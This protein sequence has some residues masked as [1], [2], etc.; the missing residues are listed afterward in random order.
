MAILLNQLFALIRLLNSETG[1][2]QIAAGISCGFILGFSPSLSIQSLVIF[3]VIFLFRIQIGAALICAFFFSFVAWLIDP[4]ADVLGAAVLE[5]ESLRPL[6]TT[7]YHLPIIPLT[8]FYNSVTMG[9]A[10]ISLALLPFVYRGASRLVQ[11]YRDTVVARLE[12]NRWWK[13]WKSTT[14]YNLYLK[15][16]SFKG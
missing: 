16:E 13:M 9:S 1:T 4:L 2:T 12:K 10:L 3:L 8:R 7:M 6:F 11:A 14:L 15:Y 5:S